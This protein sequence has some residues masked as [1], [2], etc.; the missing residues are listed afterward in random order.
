M[1]KI[2]KITLSGMFLSLGILLPFLTGQIPEFGNMLLPM[3]IPVLL[4]GMLCGWQWGLLTGFITPILRFVLFHMPP[5]YPKGISMAFELMAYGAIS[6][7]VYSRLQKKISS[8]YIALISAMIGG[9]LVWA[10]V[11]LVLLGLFKNSFTWTIFISSAF[12][13]AIPGILIQ[14]IFIPVIVR[15]TD[16]KGY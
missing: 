11:Q 12:T 9:R 7:L 4:C 13:N 1:S 3:H 5:I 2:K 16:R 6:G 10:A 8:L 14:L 15:I